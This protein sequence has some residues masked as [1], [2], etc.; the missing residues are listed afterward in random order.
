[1]GTTL[2]HSRVFSVKDSSLLRL[3]FCSR[4]LSSSFLSAPASCL[5]KM[6]LPKFQSRSFLTSQK[7]SRFKVLFCS[8][9]FSVKAYWLFKSYPFKF[10]LLK[11]VICW[12]LLSAQLVI[13]STYYLLKNVFGSSFFSL[14]SSSV[15]K[16]TV[17]SNLLSFKAPPAQTCY[18]R[19]RIL[20]VQTFYLV[21]LLL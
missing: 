10:Y 16:L 14:H 11:P 19:I 21:K 6:F 5:R 13:C 1:M 4:L 9:F 17:R 3:V 18:P 20:S 2:I 12:S 15:L 7:F 8:S